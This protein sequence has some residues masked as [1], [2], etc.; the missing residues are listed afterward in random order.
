MENLLRRYLDMRLS[1]EPAISRQGPVVTLSRECGCPSK[2]LAALM[3]EKLAGVSRKP[4]GPP[5]AWKW[6]GKELLEQAAADLQVSPKDIDHVF[7]YEEHSLVDDI[8]AATKKTGKYRTDRAIYNSIGKVIRT[9]GE[10]GHVIIVGRAGM[11]LTRHIPLSLHVRLIAPLEW[12]ITSSQAIF[13][14]NRDEAVKWIANKDE[15]RKK[16]LE[17]YLGRKFTMDDFD[18]VYNCATWDLADIAD[19][20]IVLMKVKKLI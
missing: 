19:S 1:N 12:R 5:V 14:L 10:N 13:N 3:V 18:V 2:K 15:N 4:Y 8:L 6:I 9:F 16:F 20:L 17:Y 11:A 7:Q